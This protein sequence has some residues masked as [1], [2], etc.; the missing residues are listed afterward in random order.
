MIKRINYLGFIIFASIFI[1]AC[2][3]D[4]PSK[5]EITLSKDIK[6]IVEESCSRCHS[7]KVGQ[8]YVAYNPEKPTV[9]LLQGKTE[10]EWRKTV[11]RMV[12]EHGCQIPGGVN[13]PTFNKI[14]DFLAQN[15]GPTVETQLLPT[16]DQELVQIACGSCHGIVLVDATN[17]SNIIMRITKSPIGGDVK[18]AAGK[19]D[20]TDTVTRMIEKNGCA[21]PGGT[22]GQIFAKIVNWLNTNVG[23]NVGQHLDP[24]TATGQQLTEM[25][26]GACH[27][28]VING[29]RVTTGNKFWDIELPLNKDFNGWKATI[30]KMIYKNNCPVPGGINGPA[31][32]KIANYLSSLA[33]PQPDLSSLTGQ[34][35]TQLFCGQCHGLVVGNTRLTLNAIGVDVTLLDGKSAGSRDDWRFTVAR[36]IEKN[37]CPVPGGVSDCSVD[38]STPFCKIV[39]YLETN[40]GPNCCGDVSG[41]SDEKIVKA[42]CGSCHGIRGYT[43]VL[44]VSPGLDMWL[45]DGKDQAD[46]ELTVSRMMN[47]NGAVIPGGQGGAIF[48]RIVNWLTANAGVGCCGY[49]PVSKPELIAQAACGTCHGIVIGGAN[50]YKRLTRGMSLYLGVVY[51]W[52]AMPLGKDVVHWTK[53]VNRMLQRRI[54]TGGSVPDVQQ[55]VAMI[56]WFVQE[57]N[58]GVYS[59]PGTQG[60]RDGRE[61]YM[62]YC[63]KCHGPTAGGAQMFINKQWVTNLGVGDPPARS[64]DILFPPTLRGQPSGMM[65][66]WPPSGDFWIMPYY[67]WNRYSTGF[68]DRRVH[69]NEWNLISNFLSQL[70]PNY[71]WSS[72]PNGQYE[73]DF[74]PPEGDGDGDGTIEYGWDSTPPSAPQ[75]VQLSV[76]SGSITVTWNANNTEK[77]FMGYLVFYAPYSSCSP[78]CTSCNSWNKANTIISSLDGLTYQMP[79]YEGQYTITGLN[80]GRY[81]ISV[82]SVDFACWSPRPVN[83]QE[84]CNTAKSTAGPVDVP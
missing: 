57:A 58:P 30:E 84:P 2:N 72:P 78:D 38:P 68:P 27:G 73:S 14:V 13:G 83:M 64:F 70:N 9:S 26:C 82:A 16:S 65:H 56:N 49:I 66:W 54:V 50:N 37:G 51:G 77:D 1:S 47:V 62:T 67:L 75:N 71:T 40:F 7:L 36:M 29:V 80:T 52:D 10:E 28:I 32:D 5:K 43:K 81:C 12:I 61:L 39:S 76:S 55:R 60:L 79:V 59:D 44:T 24:N 3:I 23:A 25:Y 63:H 45:F 69:N 4:K 17:P 31:V 34:E 11:S 8:E 15:Y 74:L 42:V 19:A 20:W 6:T 53:T 33:I 35:L 22:Q 48:N 41:W 18:L 46:W 21:I